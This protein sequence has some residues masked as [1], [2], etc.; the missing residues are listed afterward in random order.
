MNKQF[1]EENINLIYYLSSRIGVR[2]SD[3]DQADLAQDVVLKIL[4]A[5]EA[6]VQDT[7]SAYVSNIMKNCLLNNMRDDQVDALSHA[8]S[9][10]APVRDEDGKHVT[11]VDII[12]DKEK[13]EKASPI[14]RF[15]Y[16]VREVMYYMP[17]VWSQVFY[18]QHYLGMSIKEISSKL[19]FTEGKVR[20]ITKRA[21]AEAV[22]LIKKL[23]KIRGT[24]DGSTL[25]EMCLVALPDHILF[26]F[27]MRYADEK[28]LI[29]IS[30]TCGRDIDSIKQT[31]ITGERMIYARYG[32]DVRRR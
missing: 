24:Y 23:P 10:D 31:I 9:L 1:V 29:D 18:M 32:L 14:T 15:K 6:A 16:R 19:D 30:Y 13:F 8:D 25:R 5:K 3:E 2:L 20:G 26:P 27:K 12:P 22:S 11:K 28:N 7:A 4:Q 21:L 17:Q